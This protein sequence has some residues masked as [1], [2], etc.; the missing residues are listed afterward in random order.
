M[1]C[2]AGRERR[3]APPAAETPAAPRKRRGVVAPSSVSLVPPPPATSRPGDPLRSARAPTPPPRH[4]ATPARTEVSQVPPPPQRGDI[5]GVDDDSVATSLPETREVSR[6]DLPPLQSNVNRE[7]TNQSFVSDALRQSFAST[8]EADIV[9]LEECDEADMLLDKLQDLFDDGKITADELWAFAERNRSRPSPVASPLSSPA[10]SPLPFAKA[11][12]P[13]EHS[14]ARTAAPVLMPAAAPAPPPPP[15]PPRPPRSAL[16]PICDADYASVAALDVADADLPALCNGFEH[17]RDYS[18]AD[19]SKYTL[20]RRKAAGG[21]YEWLTH[22]QVRVDAKT[23]FMASNDYDHRKSWDQYLGDT[24]TLARF[25][26]D[27]ECCMYYMIDYGN[28]LVKNRDCVYFREVRCGDGK[29]VC[30]FRAGTHK[31]CAKKKGLIRMTKMWGQSVCRSSPRGDGWC[32][33]RCL[34]YEDMEGSIPAWALNHAVKH[35]VPGMLQTII[36]VARK[37]KG[38]DHPEMLKLAS[39]DA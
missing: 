25:D 13:P 28:F 14:P 22:G 21:L 2:C 35:M 38:G 29:Y 8:V 19:G 20:C 30:V 11:P 5:L 16:S 17:V 7:Q 18:F 31:D 10:L 27:R 1:G 15:A 33:Y 24:K 12:T 37:Y 3:P 4:T 39:G 26:G 9:Q 36:K 34:Y 32:D 23:Y 6:A